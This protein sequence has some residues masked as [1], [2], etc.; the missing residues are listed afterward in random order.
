MGV[1]RA[2]PSEARRNLLDDPGPRKCLND[3]FSFGRLNALSR[4]K[5]HAKST[6]FVA[7]DV[8]AEFVVLVFVFFKEHVGIVFAELFIDFDILD[9]GDFLVAGFFGVGVFERDD[10]GAAASSTSSS[11]SS[12]SS[13]LPCG[14]D[15]EGLPARTCSK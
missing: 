1:R 4:P 15:G 11:T 13:S 5:N 7:A 10:L 3:T 14:G 8:K 12:S 9:L 2:N 6:V